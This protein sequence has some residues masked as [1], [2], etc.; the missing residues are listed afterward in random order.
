MDGPLPGVAVPLEQT[1]PVTSL[2]VKSV[3]AAPS[4][5][6]QAAPGKPLM[7]RGVAWSGDAGPVTRVDVSVDGGR[8]WK[9]ARLRQDQSSR[10]GWRQWELE[11]TPREP[12]YYTILSRAR[13]AAGQ[14][15]P[16]DQ[17]W[18]PSGYL[19]NVVPRVG[20]EVGGERSEGLTP[21]E[22]PGSDV[23][24]PDAF[25][26]ACLVCHDEDIIGQQRLARAQWD[27]E[28][29]KMVGWGAKVTADDRP[30]FVDDL[31]NKYGPRR[32]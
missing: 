8:S 22:T 32:R 13:D 12:A 9:P 5:G 18:N 4:D 31:T 7:I 14:T 20:V 30:R 24:S 26:N 1:Q 23:R 17:E 29:Q 2:R 16:L 19:W 21:A 11:W 6:A 10:F 27:R 15:Q 25:K 28:I 3:I